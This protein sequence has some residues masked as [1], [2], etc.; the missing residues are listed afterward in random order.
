MYRKLL[1]VLAAT[2]LALPA[3]RKLIQ[4]ITLRQNRATLLT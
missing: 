1:P 3:V 4:W 2:L